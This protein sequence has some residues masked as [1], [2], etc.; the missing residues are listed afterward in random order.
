[1]TEVIADARLITC[2]LPKGRARLIQEM[3]AETYD[4]HGA[5]FHGARG[6]GRFSPLSTRGIGGQQEKEVLEVC[7]S[8][9]QADEVFEKMF[10]A[11][12]MDQPH[13]GIIYMARLT[14]GMALTMPT[15]EATSPAR[16][17]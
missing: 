8:A 15:L 6:V 3:L 2:I 10:F 1:M 7:V 13:G 14:T 4:L 9:E 12:E 5:N 16:G 11:G 17:Q